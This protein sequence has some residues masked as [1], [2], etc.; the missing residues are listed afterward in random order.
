[1]EM[2]EWLLEMGADIDEMPVED[3]GTWARREEFGSPLHWAAE[4]K[5]WDIVKQLL[6]KGA[7]KGLKDTQGR[8]VLERGGNDEVLRRLLEEH[9]TLIPFPY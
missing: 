5:N 8:T 2:T 9:N 6:E 1:M 7:D 3:E 4:G